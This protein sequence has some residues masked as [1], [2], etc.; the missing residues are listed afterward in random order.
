MTTKWNDG[1]TI[2]TR[3]FER[4]VRTQSDASD[5][6]KIALKTGKPG[7]QFAYL[8]RRETLRL[9]ANLVRLLLANLRE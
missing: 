7:F 1:R 4:I 8:N 5:A 6:S 3:K 9:I 2:V